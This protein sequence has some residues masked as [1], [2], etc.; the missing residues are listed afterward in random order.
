MQGRDQL[1]LSGDG[2][3]VRQSLGRGRA[4]DSRFRPA[5]GHKRQSQGILHGIW[6]DR[7]R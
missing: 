1:V 4:I 3:D 5:G 6:N 7:I 2:L